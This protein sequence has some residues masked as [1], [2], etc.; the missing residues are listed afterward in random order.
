MPI[1]FPVRRLALIAAIRSQASW[2]AATVSLL[3]LILALPSR[4]SARIIY[5]T[6]LADKVSDRDGCSLKEAIYSANLG[7]NQAIT[8]F[9]LTTG[10][11]RTIVTTCAPGTGNDTI[12][13]PPGQLLAL[14]K[15]TDDIG[16][17]VGATA[18]PMITSNIT[19][20][21]YGAVLQW[22][23]GQPARAF[24]IASTGSLTIYDTRITGFSVKGGNGVF[25]GGGGMGAG[26]AIYVQGGH[27]I[28]EN[29]T[30]DA[31]G[32]VGGSG[33]GKGY[34]DTGGGGGGGGL[35]GNGGYPSNEDF[36]GFRTGGGGG[37][38]A[39]G[40]GYGDLGNV[41]GNG[42]GGGGGGTLLEGSTADASE[43]ETDHTGGLAC[44]GNSGAG[45][46]TFVSTGAPGS[47][48]PCAGGGGGGG[49]RG[50]AQCCSN[51]GGKGNYGGGGGGGASGGGN[52][53]DGGFGGGGG[54]GWAGLLGGT[55]GG[56]SLFG[57]G[58]GTGPDGLLGSIVAGGHPGNG[59]MFGGRADSRYGGGGAGLGGAIFN[60][61]GGVL[62]E[63]STFTNNFVSHGFSGGGSADP[64]ADAGG[65]IFT[66]DGHLRVHNSTIAGNQSTGSGG[67]VVIVQTAQDKDTLLGIE[68]T[69]IYNN[70]SM[71]AQGNLTDAAAECS[72]ASGFAVAV[73]GAGNLIQNNDNCQGVVSTDDPQLGP[74]QNNR[75]FTP[76]MAIVENTPAWNTADPGSSLRADQRGQRRPANG[77]FDIGAFELCVNTSDKFN[78]CVGFEGVPNPVALTILV[79][80]PTFGTTS[81][82]PGN[83]SPNLGSIVPLQAIPNPGYAFS[84]WSGNVGNIFA[85]STSIVM[86]EP[87]TVTANFA[88]CTCVADVTGYVGIVRGGLVLNLATGRYAQTVTVTNNAPFTIIGPVSLV[89]DSLSSNASLFS[90][91][92]VTDAAW[93]PAGSAFIN[94]NVTLLPGQQASFALQF[95]DPSRAAIT[96]NTRVL[97]GLGPR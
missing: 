57:G 91:T 8:G 81:P 96:Y 72:I 45:Q 20:L 69:I 40:N 62:V 4:S 71:D 48:A 84:S 70:G 55:R 32:A 37:G 24:S 77:G 15:I 68:N 12:V 53:A 19:I 49:G 21:G 51:D 31:N 67:G 2:L 90:P 5:V 65:A 17:P 87:Q 88:L 23:G 34:G 64:G 94:A 79:Q 14:T 44:G 35:G 26:G 85:A 58:G 50:A 7:S 3:L 25:G 52:G 38:G 54:A 92:G 41:G 86:L 43:P 1:A 95:T 10:S 13:L 60:D 82:A 9:D 39:R 22:A 75:G 61:S 74:L 76:T 89:L 18:T 6:T 29:C 73:D 16:N 47:D 36:A 78:P 11:P 33:G 30:F 56:T 42:S 83:H 93:P 66:V 97:A 63:N 46:T 27:L 28:V 59:G 80:P